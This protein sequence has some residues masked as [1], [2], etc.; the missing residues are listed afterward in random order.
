M[1][2]LA[3][4][5]LRNKWVLRVV[6]RFLSEERQERITIAQFRNELCFFGHDASDMT[7]EE[8]KE[9]IVKVGELI[10]QFGFT[11]DEAGNV[12]KVMA[13]LSN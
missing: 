7:D 13:Q 11:A 4:Y 3:N 6:T 10:G 2:T 8:I 12:I 1:K 9:A 5:L